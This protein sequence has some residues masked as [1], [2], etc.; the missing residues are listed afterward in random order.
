MLP[1]PGTP[2]IGGDATEL[3]EVLRN[4]GKLFREAGLETAALDARL[5][6]SHACG[7]SRE[8][9]ITRPDFIVKPAIMASL[10]DSAKRRLSGEPVSRIVGMREF[11]GLP[12]AL[13]AHTLDPRPETEL[14]VE[15]VL[16]H[17]RDAGLTGKPLRILD[18]GTGSGCILAA[19]LSE[20]PFAFGVGVDRS[21][22]ALI[23]ARENMRE[24]G[25][26]NRASF[27]CSDWTTALGP[28]T[29][30]IIVSNPP[31]I[32]SSE[33]KELEPQVRAYDPLLAL[34]GGEDGLS[35]FQAILD[36]AWAVLR[37]DGFLIFETGYRQAGTVR[38]MMAGGDLKA[39]R[40]KAQIFLD[41]SGRER[42]VAGWKSSV[43]CMI[44]SKKKVGDPA[45]SG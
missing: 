44:A 7:L 18:L 22:E 39:R 9:T 3:S 12:F 36:G 40:F 10:N 26:L 6:A 8:E 37:E 1:I 21:E 43:G 30:D 27:L 41:L 5:L 35:A 2:P 17:V 20:L 34:D 31:Y 29:F 28:G 38:D 14:L 32:A 15:T 4:L 23:M 19:L 25:L 16:S 45:L 13:S 33:I 42:V 24:L 11:W